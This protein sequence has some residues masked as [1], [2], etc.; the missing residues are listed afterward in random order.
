VTLVRYH[1]RAAPVPPGWRVAGPAPGH[2]G[3]RFLILEEQAMHAPHVRDFII[4]PTL[5]HLASDD[6]P[7]VA[8]EAAVQLVLG[9]ALA[10]SRLVWLVQHGG[11]PA[12]GLYQMEPA[13]LEWLWLRY[14]P[15]RQPE[16]YQRALALRSEAL[17]RE[18]EIVWNLAWATALCRARYL[19]VPE[20][21]PE[22]GDLD[23][24]G[25][26]WKRYYNTA[27][28]AGTVAHF[29]EATRDVVA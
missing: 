14:L 27:A 15:E 4:R 25:D 1:E 19:P 8:S 5:R 20:P 12:L 2:H 21:L 13:T 9:T 28:G 6:M 7:W 22:A 26:Y 17:G 23:A 24:L 16:I 18:S 29:V 3:R 10:E 11:G